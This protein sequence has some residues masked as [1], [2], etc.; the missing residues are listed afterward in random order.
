MTPLSALAMMVFV[1]FYVPCLA[2]VAA[3]RRETDSLKWTVF[4][5]VYNT[6]VAWGMA[7]VIYQG[8][9]L[10]GLE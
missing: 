5:V 1:L 3:I 9:K 6:A 2:T 7:F 10:I 4:S 8:G